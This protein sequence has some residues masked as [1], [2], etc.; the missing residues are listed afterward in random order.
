VTNTFYYAEKEM[1]FLEKEIK[2]QI[3]IG[4]IRYN[5]KRILESIN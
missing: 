4:S 3:S 2:A 5:L 1:N